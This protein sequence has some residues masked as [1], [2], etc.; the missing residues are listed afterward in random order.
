MKLIK[1]YDIEQIEQII[2]EVINLFTQSNDLYQKHLIYELFNEFLKAYPKTKLINR[3]ID[4][5][6][7]DFIENHSFEVFDCFITLI[8]HGIINLIPH[9]F[10]NIIHPTFSEISSTYTE[11]PEHRFLFY[12]LIQSIFNHFPNIDQNIFHDLISYTFFGIKHPQLDISEISINCISTILSKVEAIPS[13]ANEFYS[14]YFIEILSNLLETIFDGMH[15]FLFTQVTQSIIHLL[16]IVAL[17]NISVLTIDDLQNAI[18]EKVQ[19]L[20]H[21]HEPHLIFS[22]AQSVIQNISNC[23]KL[24]QIFENFIIKLK[25]ISINQIDPD[26][27]EIDSFESNLKMEL[28]NDVTDYSIYIDNETELDEV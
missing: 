20:F 24:R 21:Y 15:S 14:I 6:T 26:I 7:N 9:V 19:A 4:I 2:T 28:L 3:L 10:N 11:H 1:C 23:S 25:T 22:F 8:N 5:L 27:L 13:M 12:T 18:Y 17:G 16:Q